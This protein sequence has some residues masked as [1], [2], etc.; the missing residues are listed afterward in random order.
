MSPRQ[1]QGQQE[2]WINTMDLVTLASHPLCQ[3]QNCLLDEHYFYPFVEARCVSFC[4]EKLGRPSIPVGVYFRM[5]L[6]VC[7]EGIDSERGIAWRGADSLGLW[8]FLGHGLNEWTLDHSSLSVIRGLLDIGTHRGVFQCVLKV[9]AKSDLLKGKTL[10][11]V[12]TTSE[13][14]AALRSI[15]CRD[16]G[17]PYEECLRDLAQASGIETLARE[18]LAEVDLGVTLWRI[19]IHEC[20]RLCE[21]GKTPPSDVSVVD[22]S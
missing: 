8:A 5:L 17:Q 12:V 19:G 11:V 16:T 7:F 9:L 18:D 15:V 20:R 14:N 13:A 4:A 1:T 10:G 6:I 2:L 3:A 22:Y 21:A